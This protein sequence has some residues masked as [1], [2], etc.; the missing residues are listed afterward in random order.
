MPSLRE[1][2]NKFNGQGLMILAV[3]AEEEAA[4]KSAIKRENIPYAVALD[5]KGATSRRF[6]NPNAS[7]AYL[8]G[9]EGKVIW[10]GHVHQLREET[11]QTAL[12]T[13]EASEKRAGVPKK[14]ATNVP[15][16]DAGTKEEKTSAVQESKP[17]R[18][19]EVLILSDG[20]RIRGRT[21][22]KSGNK[23]FFKGEDGKMKSYEAGEV[24]KVE[25]EE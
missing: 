19:M 9:P 15:K 23:L 13:V 24:E 6:P 25:R 21:V 18:A 7:Y 17:A 11:V 5:P 16:P 1:L 22:S 12:R 3:T 10:T 14:A 20:T 4:V 2:H 8:I